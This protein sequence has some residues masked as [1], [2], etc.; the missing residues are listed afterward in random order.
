MKKLLVKMVDK[1]LGLNGTVNFQKA[2]DAILEHLGTDATGYGV[3]I[4]NTVK[5][6]APTAN[7]RFILSTRIHVG[8][9]IQ[10]KTIVIVSNILPAVGNNCMTLRGI[11]FPELPFGMARTVTYSGNIVGVVVINNKALRGILKGEGI[12]TA[13]LHH[14]LGHNHYFAKYPVGEA[15]NGSLFEQ[16]LG[17]TSQ[18]LMGEEI[19]ADRWATEV[20][21]EEVMLHT[22]RAIENYIG[23]YNKVKLLGQA[24]VA[25]DKGVAPYG[26]MTD[27]ELARQLEDRLTMASEVMTG[28]IAA[29]TGC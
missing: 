29:L 8:L 13:V 5:S 9:S 26:G 10:H 17:K 7:E 25:R 11:M 3:A 15:T 28:R 14:E 24:K 6:I 12:A 27:M 19:Q 1:L 4:G 2:P 21:G 22:L 18:E 20:V 16:Q 23:K